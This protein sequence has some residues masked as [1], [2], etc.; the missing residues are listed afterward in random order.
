VSDNTTTIIHDWTTKVHRDHALACEAVLVSIAETAFDATL[1][2]AKE[3]RIPVPRFTIEGVA[4]GN[5]EEF[6]I[7]LTNPIQLA[8]LARERIKQLKVQKP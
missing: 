3:L 5:P 8:M 2:G 6:V 1:K 7:D 4:F